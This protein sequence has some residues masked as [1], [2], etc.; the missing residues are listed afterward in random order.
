MIQLDE[1]LRPMWLFGSTLHEGCD[2][3]GYYEQAQFVE[4]YGSPS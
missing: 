1:A 4:E 3:S 2:R